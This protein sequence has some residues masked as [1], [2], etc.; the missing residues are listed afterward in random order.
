MQ[1]QLYIGKK[2]LVHFSNLFPILVNEMLKYVRGAYKNHGEKKR[3]IE[4]KKKRYC[5][6]Y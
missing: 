1:S 4:R 3:K 2:F 6:I 5:E